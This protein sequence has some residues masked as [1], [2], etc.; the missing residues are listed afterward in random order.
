[1]FARKHLII[2]GL[3][4][5]NNECQDISPLLAVL[6]LY[7][8]VNKAILRGCQSVVFGRVQASHLS[9]GHNQETVTTAPRYTACNRNCLF[10][11]MHVYCNLVCEQLLKKLP[12]KLL[13]V[14]DLWKYMHSVYAVIWCVSDF[15]KS[16]NKR[17]RGLDALLELKTQY[18]RMFWKV[19]NRIKL[20]YLRY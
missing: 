13:Y 8:H 5:F 3:F 20:C 18:T 4:N 14:Y 9:L 12:K 16:A 2:W 1:M 11:Y 15:L 10:R 17:P 19:V 6:R 7:L